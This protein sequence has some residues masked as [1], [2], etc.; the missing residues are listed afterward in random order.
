MI[1]SLHMVRGS[2]MWRGKGDGAV[3]VLSKANL[4]QADLT[5]KASILAYAKLLEGHSFQEILDLGI[6]PEGDYTIRDYSGNK[7][8]GKYGNIIEERYFGYRQNSKR[9]QD[10]RQAGLEL[11][12]SCIDVLKGGKVSVGERLVLTMIAYNEPAPEL[13]EDSHAWEKGH[14]ILLVYYIRQKKAPASD[15]YINDVLIFSPPAKDIPIIRQ[16]YGI[17]RNLIVAGMAEKLSESL[18]SYLSACTKGS[19][20]GAV[21]EQKLYAPGKTAKARAWSYKRSYM[22]Y[23]YKTF[24]LGEA[25]EESII[26]EPAL[27]EERSFDDIIISKLSPFFGMTDR[28]ICE[29]FGIEFTGDKRQ[30][31]AITYRMLGVTSN[32]AEEFTKANIQVKTVRVESNGDIRESM[33]FPHF[34]FKDIVNE[35]W[36]ES[37]LRSIFEETRFLFVVFEKTSDGCVLKGAMFWSMPEDDLDGP[38]QECW[39]RTVSTINAGVVF[40]LKTLSNGTVVVENNLPKKTDNPISHVRPH[41]SLSA[42]KLDNGYTVGNLE[43]H[44]DELPDGQWMTKQCFWLNNTYVKEIIEPVIAAQEG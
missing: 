7:S 43:A 12:V 1:Y 2:M 41:T 42:Y 38:L 11:K 20:K 15:Q 4:E 23:I 30:W 17:I 29:R 33:S 24:I 16:D 3:P 37:E 34:R 26:K 14:N 10:F 35:T 28:R 39:E 5:D 9:E 8:K 18:T 6:I 21:K 44:G 32:K 13:L 36:E 31:A 27:L 40:N 25:E 19:G 22:D